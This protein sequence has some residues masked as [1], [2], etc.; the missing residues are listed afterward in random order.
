MIEEMSFKF[1]FFCQ[2]YQETYLETQNKSMM[3]HFWK[4][5]NF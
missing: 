2:Y 3:E 5:S 4:N 1:N